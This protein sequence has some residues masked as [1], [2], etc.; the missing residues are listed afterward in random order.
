MKKSFSACFAPAYALCAI[1][2]G[3]FLILVILSSF[4]IMPTTVHA[5]LWAIGLLIG[6]GF[7]FS[8]G[9]A[10]TWVGISDSELT[11]HT[12]LGAD[13]GSIP[14]SV[15]HTRD[16][17]ISRIND[18]KLE[19]PIIEESS[20]SAKNVGRFLRLFF[21]LFSKPKALGLLIFAA[22]PNDQAG[23]EDFL[24]LSWTSVS[25]NVHRKVLLPDAYS[26]NAPIYMKVAGWLNQN[27]IELQIG[28]DVR[29]DDPSIYSKGKFL[30]GS[31]LMVPLIIISAVW[32]LQ[33]K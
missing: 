22:D 19:G 27:G 20:A 13:K 4:R 7:L 16:L 31:L 5:I 17:F 32:Y 3:T 25:S 33:F 30:L 9:R 2:S 12:G 14:S 28:N 6:F 8:L 11:F 29:F 23:I 10:V 26:W 1:L 15:D 21:D 18:A 24:V